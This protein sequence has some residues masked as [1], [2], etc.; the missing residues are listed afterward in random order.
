MHYTNLK[1]EPQLL[2]AN[3]SELMEKWNEFNN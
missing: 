3:R 1:I 2:L